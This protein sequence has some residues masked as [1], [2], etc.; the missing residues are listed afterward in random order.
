M[1]RMSHSEARARS[2]I[3]NQW[4]GEGG[5]PLAAVGLDPDNE[6]RA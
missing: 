2:S 3:E 6:K 5:T 1:A 4:A